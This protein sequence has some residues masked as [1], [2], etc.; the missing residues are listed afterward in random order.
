MA[1]T[2]NPISPE[3]RK[4]LHIQVVSLREER[5][6][7]LEERKRLRD[8]IDRLTAQLKK[9]AERN[10]ELENKLDER[11]ARLAQKEAE[12]EVVQRDAAMKEALANQLRTEA[13]T[14]QARHEQA[15][16]EQARRA[17]EEVIERRRTAEAMESEKFR[18]M[19]EVAS[20]RAEC[21]T[22]EHQFQRT[23]A[24]ASTTRQLLE[25]ARD[26]A[27]A[28]ANRT[29][30]SLNAALAEQRTLSD[31][32][33]RAQAQMGDE[34]ALLEMRAESA[35]KRWAE[36]AKRNDELSRQRQRLEHERAKADESL[37]VAMHEKRFVES[38]LADERS[39]SVQAAKREGGLRHQLDAAEWAFSNYRK[40]HD[41]L[42]PSGGSPLSHLSPSSIAQSS[43]PLPPPPTNA[44][45]APASSPSHDPADLRSKPTTDP[46]SIVS[47]EPPPLVTPTGFSRE[48]YLHKATEAYYAS[49]RPSVMEAQAAMQAAGIHEAR[50]TASSAS[51]AQADAMRRPTS[52]SIAT[53][54]VEPPE[55]AAVAAAR[56]ADA[57]AA[58]AYAAHSRPTYLHEPLSHH[59][60]YSGSHLPY[61]LSP[62]PSYPS[63]RLS[64]APLHPTQ[65][66]P[67]TSPSANL[68]ARLQSAAYPPVG[69]S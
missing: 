49:L 54:M 43:A 60:P 17:A 29:E 50:A 2:T 31:M 41:A 18:L 64:P 67:Y 52:P 9:A 21:K 65:L 15:E 63:S 27:V 22:A 39:L 36:A 59:S 7:L 13:T 28:R 12:L 56:A 16:T 48:Y 61:P 30:E 62:P 47:A 58:A 37:A 55:S 10:T 23:A 35:E 8:E 57:A 68:H 46:P 25:A 66:P 20:A 4:P 38:Q 24:E 26:E 69:L 1:C 33:Q 11:E 42:S 5:V 19:G 14:W 51:R 6:T 32:L 34:K 40:V 53:K 44:E 45:A 3:Q